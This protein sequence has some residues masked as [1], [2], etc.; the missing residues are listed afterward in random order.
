MNKREAKRTAARMVAVMI[1]NCIAADI[2]ND[3]T[4]FA[5]ASEADR[6]RL[7]AALEEIQQEMIL[8]GGG[9]LDFSEFHPPKT[10]KRQEKQIKLPAKRQW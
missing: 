5:D 2:G 7:L 10:R 4:V 3:E 8:R 1:D 6:A 9:R